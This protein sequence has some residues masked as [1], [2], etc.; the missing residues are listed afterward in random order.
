MATRENSIYYLLD[1]MIRRGLAS[2]SNTWIEKA[3]AQRNP[4]CRSG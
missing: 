3:I 2:T 4:H 1:A